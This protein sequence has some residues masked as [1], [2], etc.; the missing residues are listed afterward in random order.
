MAYST[1][2]QSSSNITVLHVNKRIY[3]TVLCRI[4][5]QTMFSTCVRF[6]TLMNVRLEHMTV[7]SSASTSRE[8]SNVPVTK[9]TNSTAIC[10][11]AMVRCLANM[12]TC[13]FKCKDSVICI[14]FILVLM[15]LLQK[16]VPLYT[17]QNC[18]YISQFY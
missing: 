18:V 5:A 17:F 12:V 7:P 10:V 15:L 11:R 16:Y 4:S 2:Q 3:M 14:G 1:S 6:Q 8:A 13:R 9:V